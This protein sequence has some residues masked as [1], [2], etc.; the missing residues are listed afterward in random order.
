MTFSKILK[1]LGIPLMANY[2][3]DGTWAPKE[4]N[5]PTMKKMKLHRQLVQVKTPFS[6]PSGDWSS[7]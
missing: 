2:Q 7:L 3:L 5:D 1:A 4:E 6:H